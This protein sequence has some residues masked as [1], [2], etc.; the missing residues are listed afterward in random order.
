MT[1]ALRRLQVI[2]NFSQHVNY[3]HIRLHGHPQASMFTNNAAGT[4]EHDEKIKRRSAPLTQHQPLRTSHAYFIYRSESNLARWIS[5]SKT[6]YNFW[7]GQLLKRRNKLIELA[8]LHKHSS[9]EAGSS[10]AT[11][12]GLDIVTG[13]AINMKLCHKHV[14][15][16]T[17][18]NRVQG[19]SIGAH[20]C[21]QKKHC[22]EET[23][24]SKT[25]SSTSLHHLQNKINETSQHSDI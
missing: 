13:I 1:T 2:S 25:K 5:Q 10:R 4:P 7:F 22:G 20:T 9:S 15:G 19:T 12:S 14:T 6:Y 3:M 8:L 16:I 17:N 11:P 18:I 24:N 21:F 23:T